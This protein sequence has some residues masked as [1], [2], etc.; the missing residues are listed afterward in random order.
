MWTS[1]DFKAVREAVLIAY[2]RRCMSCGE[3]ADEVHHIRPRH[4]GG[5]DHPRNLVPLCEACHDEV[6]RRLDAAVSEAIERTTRSMLE[7]SE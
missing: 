5:T 7:A 1:G 2:G 6:H 4:L 3:P